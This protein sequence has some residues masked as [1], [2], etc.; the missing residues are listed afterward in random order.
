MRSAYSGMC[1][2]EPGAAQGRAPGIDHP[3]GRVPPWPGD[4]G[5]S[6]TRRRRM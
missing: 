4:I 6:R 3:P 1:A 5:D 2:R